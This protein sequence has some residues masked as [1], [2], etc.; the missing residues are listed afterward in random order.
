M[1]IGGQIPWNVTTICETVRISCL[2]GRLH[3][4]DVLENPLKDQSF[5]LVHWLSI[6]LSLRKTSQKCI[7][8]ERKFFLD[9]SSDT[10]ST[11]GEFGR[12]TY[13][14]QTSRS[15]KRWTH[16]KSTLK[17]LMRKSDISTQKKENLFFQSQMDESEPLEEI[18][19]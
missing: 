1:K 5:R 17:D 6:T 18:R 11:R 10:L 12:V 2:K 7:N 16:R 9:C 13:W 3:T 4:R 19:T 8:S 14:L 15:W